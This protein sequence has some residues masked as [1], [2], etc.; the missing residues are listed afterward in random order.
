[1]MKFKN[2]KRF[3]TI[4]RVQINEYIVLVIKERNANI[5]IHNSS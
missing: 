4:I 2:E 5:F 3:L 1:M